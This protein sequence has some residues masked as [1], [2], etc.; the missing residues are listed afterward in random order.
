MSKPELVGHDSF[1]MKELNELI[2]LKQ[3]Y[4]YWRMHQ[5]TGVSKIKFLDFNYCFYV[6]L[7]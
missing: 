4:D 1:Y 6:S 3:D 5:H 2:D 7:G